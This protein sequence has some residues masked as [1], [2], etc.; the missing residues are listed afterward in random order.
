MFK[1][2]EEISV[3]A[4]LCVYV[5]VHPSPFPN[6]TKTTAYCLSMFQAEGTEIQ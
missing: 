6:T 5:C 2:S 1:F 4:Y 3:Y